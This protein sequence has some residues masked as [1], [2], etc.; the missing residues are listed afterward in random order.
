MS[1]DPLDALEGRIPLTSLQPA[2]VGAVHPEDFGEGFLA[3]P[4]R[5]PKVAQ[6]SS[7]CSL[8][9]SVTHTATMLGRYL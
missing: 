9:V 5:D 1:R 3:Q 2:H 4:S 8:Q 7:K 6:I